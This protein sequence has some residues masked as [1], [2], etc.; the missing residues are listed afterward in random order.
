YNY[1]YDNLNRLIAADAMVV[2]NSG[3]VP[4]N[5]SAWGDA[6]YDY[7][8]I[9]NIE[10]LSRGVVDDNTNTVNTDLYEYNYA[11]N[12][13]RLQSV[14]QSGEADRLFSYDENGNLIGDTKKGLSVGYGRANLPWSMT[15]TEEDGTVTESTY[16]YDANDARIVKSVLTRS[17]RHEY[18]LRSSA[19]QELAVYDMTED[20]ITWY[21]HG[22]ER[23]AKVAQI[24]ESGY[25]NLPGSNP[26]S[27]S[28]DPNAPDCTPSE[29]L[30]QQ[31]ILP[32]LFAS[33]QDPNRSWTFPTM[34]HRIRL[35]DATEV[36]LFAEE[37]SQLTGTYTTL[38]NI[39]ITGF[40]QEFIL[41]GDGQRT[42]GLF[43]RQL[44]VALANDPNAY[45]NDYEPCVNTGSCTDVKL[46]PAHSVSGSNLW[47]LRHSIA[48]GDLTAL[49]PNA[50]NSLADDGIYWRV[51]HTGGQGFGIGQDAE[52]DVSYQFNDPSTTTLTGYKVQVE[53]LAQNLDRGNLYI[54]MHNGSEFVSFNG[55]QDSL[56]ITDGAGNGNTLLELIPDTL[57]GLSE[58]AQMKVTIL[59]VVGGN[60]YQID[61]VQAEVSY[62]TECGCK[63][64]LPTCDPS[65]ITQQNAN[66]QNLLVSIQSRTP[67]NMHFPTRLY[68]TRFCDATEWSVLREEMSIVD[69]GTVISQGL[70]IRDSQQLFRVI[71]SGGEQVVDLQGMLDIR[72]AEP[73]AEI[74]L[75]C[76]G[77]SPLPDPFDEP[78]EEEEEAGLLDLTW[79]IQDHLGNTRVT[80]HTTFDCGEEVKY[81]LDHVIDYYP[82]GKV[83]REFIAGQAERYQTTHHER[84]QE[85][86]LDYRG[87]RFYDSD[88]ARFLSLD[89]LAMT[90]A[91][92]SDYVYVAGMPVIAVDP[93]GRAI[94][95]ISGDPAFKAAVRKQ[96]MIIYQTEV[97]RQV[98]D[99]LNA[100]G[101]PDVYIREVD[102]TLLN[103]KSAKYDTSINTV[104]I[105][106]SAVKYGGWTPGFNLVNTPG[107]IFLGHELYHAYL[108]VIVY[109]NDEQMQN[110]FA[111]RG[112]RR[113]KHER[114]TMAFENYL[115]RI[116]LVKESWRYGYTF[117][118]RWKSEAWFKQQHNLNNSKE[119][120][121]WMLGTKRDDT[122]QLL[123][124]YWI[125]QEETTEKREVPVVPLDRV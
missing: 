92:L 98:I 86:G 81:V 68:N 93:D 118:K 62:E 74:D 37:L 36:H 105:S 14:E 123:L 44:P 53:I 38:Q 46:Y 22:N 12:G 100:P 96:L 73:A 79:Y 124:R 108:D 82:Y 11:P 111:R 1:N 32:S 8:K 112:K 5:Q 95:I 52:W 25:K 76:G 55:G 113:E 59:Q 101:M 69:G 117:K 83:L 116:F 58:L 72:D 9:G 65:T 87:A 125:K 78:L 48:Y 6:N 31:T 51:T 77:D 56:D 18:Y 75:V 60:I 64:D 30:Q 121:I 35:C 70:T 57:P 29:Q 21:I 71:W 2:V 107:Y 91:T 80:Y 23:V 33:M 45:V 63:G 39:S 43:L 17:L 85:T 122:G 40:D 88:I 97:G 47:T 90:F 61:V 49:S 10:Y 27:K 120:R 15:T 114:R 16:L 24:G 84:D 103:A 4:G 42:I 41:S 20:A 26:P 7:D 66:R 28:C 13:N 34:L 99:A 89:P 104:Y 106:K 115:R 50:E 19:G 3:P 110:D 102:W 94:I 67:G 109:N 119:E 54:A